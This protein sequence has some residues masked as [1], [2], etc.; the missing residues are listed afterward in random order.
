MTIERNKVLDKTTKKVVSSSD[1]KTIRQLWTHITGPGKVTDV[2]E[3]WLDINNFA[4]W[5]IEQAQ[6]M[7]HPM[8]DLAVVRKTALSGSTEY[9]PGN[10]ILLKR[11]H[12]IY[13]TPLKEGGQPHASDLQKVVSNTPES[14]T[15][16]HKYLKGFTG[17]G[18]AAPKEEKVTDPLKVRTIPNAT[19]IC[20]I[21]HGS[22]LYGTNTPDSDL[23]LIGVYIPDP[24][25]AALGLVKDK[26]EFGT[27]DKEAKN[28]KDDIDETYISIGRF[29]ERFI[30]GDHRTFD[31]VHADPKNTLYATEEWYDIVS[32]RALMYTKDMGGIT[33]Y[34]RRECRSHGITGTRPVV[35]NNII[36]LLQD[37][38]DAPSTVK[39]TQRRFMDFP[40]LVDTLKNMATEYP[41]V[42]SILSD[43]LD[44]HDLPFISL[45]GSK[46]GMKSPLHQ[47]VQSLTSKNETANRRLAQ[48]LDGVDVDWK[49]I[50]HAMRHAQQVI[51]VHNTGTLCYPLAGREHLKDVKAG[52]LPFQDV[53]D[54]LEDLMETIDE[55]ELNTE[56]PKETSRVIVNLVFSGII[57]GFYATKFASEIG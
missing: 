2:C 53:K 1:I 43:G 4:L 16:T 41:S 6:T 5:F 37:S 42:V 11:E 26:Y 52:L 48:N 15:Q 9:T 8:S 50:H 20:L 14:A 32:M 28:T 55:L 19:V 12:A 18:K 54:E 3:K 29:M 47:A 24:S 56:Y 30:S 38:L 44:D 57:D 13:F 51:E 39:K 25:A 35:I 21:R 36:D 23:D 22:S 7:N 34:I 27:S 31:M 40:T 10:C 17:I 49:S 46:F 33:A 45:A